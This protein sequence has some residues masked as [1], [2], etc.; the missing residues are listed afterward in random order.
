MLQHH[1]EIIRRLVHDQHKEMLRKA[2]QEPFLPRTKRSKPE[3][4][5]IAQ[6]W[7]PSIQSLVRLMESAVWRRIL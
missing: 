3:L 1:P 7:S 5:V 6:L 4:R 2:W